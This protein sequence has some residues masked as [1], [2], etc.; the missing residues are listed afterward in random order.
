MST[1]HDDRFENLIDEAA[2]AVRG[3]SL[4]EGEVAAAARRAAEALAAEAGA[5]TAA[6]AAAADRAAHPLWGCTEIQALLPA[7]HDGTLGPDR[8][9]L[10]DEHLKGCVTCRAAAKRVRTGAPAL[11]DRRRAAPAAP[12]RRRPR[13]WAWAAA[14]AVV[15][16]A[17]GGTWLLQP[18]WIG[19][20][21]ST[22]TV[23]ELDGLLLNVGR[24][25]AM[26]IARGA[27]VAYG[28]TMR[29]GKEA[30][31]VVVLAD[32]SRIELAPRTELTLARAADGTDIRLGGGQV[33]VEASKQGSGHLYVTTPDSRVAVKGT[34]FSVLSGAKGTRVSVLE[35]AVEVDHG[36]ERA[37]LRPG[38]QFTSSPSL[39]GASL[40]DEIGWSRDADRHRALL[41]EFTALSHAIDA[42]PGP[43]PRTSTRLMD[44]MPQDAVFFAAL[45]NLA[46]RVDEAWRL[47]LERAHGN[48]TLGA[49]W[50]EHAG[51]QHEA[52][53]SAVVEK[54]RLV[55]GELGDEI[56]L[57]A[58]AG[59]PDRP[60]SGLALI[61][62]VK[63]EASFRAL[64]E[65]EV[66]A[67]AGQG[68]VPFRLV[69][70]AADVPSE[71]RTDGSPARPALYLTTRGDLLLAATGR[72]ALAALE[73]AAAAG[74]GG[75]VGT[76][77]RAE[78]ARS[79]RD[80][81]V[82]L[83]GVDVAGL[84]A[85]GLA[86]E[87]EGGSRDGAQQAMTLTG[88]AGAK[89]LVLE[90][91]GEG[92]GSTLHATLVFDG[93]RTGALA[94]LAEPSPMGALRFVSPDATL[95]V[96]AVVKDP[97][98]MLDESYALLGGRAADIQETLGKLGGELGLDVRAD[99]LA[100][101][102]GEFVFALDG[103]I[104][105][106]PAWKV[107][108]EVYD[109]Q[110][111]QRT[112]EQVV[113]RAAEQAAAQQRPVPVLTSAQENGRTFYQ[114]ASQPPTMEL[115][116]TFADGYLVL[117]SQRTLLSQALDNARAGI[118][119]ATAPA[120]VSRLP[121]DGHAS[122]SGLVWRD[123]ARLASAFSSLPMPDESKALLG[124]LQGGPMLDV[125][126]GEPDRI[127][128]AGAQ[129]SLTRMLL[130]ALIGGPGPAVSPEPLP[131]GESAAR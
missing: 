60:F 86:S 48:E 20:G 29:T 105:P 94:W 88:L 115:H 122:V 130:P 107:A 45:P 1:P 99:L 65:R 89:F 90:G 8:M 120:F 56:A 40:E 14:A 34:V 32:G 4:A 126:Y 59:G 54:V 95:A 27:K 78:L 93:P 26:P 77:L 57:A 98:E 72:D 36:E 91:D 123:T 22:A 15:L 6:A 112:I 23:A 33:I 63:N 52:E 39:S 5:G 44:L 7:R 61:A 19:I 30:G 71:V 129:R 82:W 17:I 37:M 117:A 125:A 131:E 68:E 127:T 108:A 41:A 35:G 42:L 70:G 75:F 3:D 25:G 104:L 74:Q 114:V 31:A 96:A 111:L 67:L 121:R 81:A 109:A 58:L 110:R 103:P 12:A 69:G 43:A 62:I 49:W 47:F 18:G 124:A 38:Q 79:F 97:V 9:L 92:E 84:V 66:A 113:A 87:P 80:G 116:Y 106:T 100:P 16:A 10:V 51:P 46:G 2:R 118:T 13:A 83:G 119:L 21:G 73:A 128:V 55:G 64:V 11:A 53:L 101:L 76:P 24:V 28:E 102:G 85:R 50:R